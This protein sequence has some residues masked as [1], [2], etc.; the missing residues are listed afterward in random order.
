MAQGRVFGFEGI[1]TRKKNRLRFV[2][3]FDLIQRCAALE[4]DG[5]EVPVNRYF[6]NHPDLIESV[7]VTQSQNFAKDKVIQ[8]SRWF[9]GAGLLTSEGPEWRRQNNTLSNP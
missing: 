4:I 8:N 3:S 1:V 2:I 9:L 6:L 7:L 5:A